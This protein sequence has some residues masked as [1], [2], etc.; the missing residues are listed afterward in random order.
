[1]KPPAP[2]F[3]HRVA[4]LTPQL[5][6]RASALSYA[7]GYYPI[8]TSTDPSW[9]LVPGTR[10]FGLELQLSK[11]DARALELEEWGED[12]RFG[13]G[14]GEMGSVGVVWPV[15]GTGRRYVSFQSSLCVCCLGGYG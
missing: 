13:D 7:C 11:T 8:F 9:G 10:N 3:L 12:G 14:M 4:H 6:L 1:M 5:C 2:A 15:G